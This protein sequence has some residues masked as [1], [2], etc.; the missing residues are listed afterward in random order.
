MLCFEME[1][2][3]TINPK[4]RGRFPAPLSQN[5]K[6]DSSA[7]KR[8]SLGE[9]HSTKTRKDQRQNDDDVLVGYLIQSTPT[10]VSSIGHAKALEMIFDF[11]VGV[12]EV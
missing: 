7:H 2:R 11:V 6:R 10:V 4:R 8:Q 3:R 12:S 9:R 1:K 5:T